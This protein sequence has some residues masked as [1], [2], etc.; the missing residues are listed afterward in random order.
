MRVLENGE[1]VYAQ[2]VRPHKE[3]GDESNNSGDARGDQKTVATESVYHAHRQDGYPFWLPIYDR[4]Q[5]WRKQ[6]LVP[7]R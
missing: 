4:R 1:T 2:F 7:D 6:A 5:V 3:R